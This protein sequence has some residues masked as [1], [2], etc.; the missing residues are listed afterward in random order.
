[1]ARLN[2]P[3][4]ARVTQQARATIPG[5]AG[6]EHASSIAVKSTTASDTPPQSRD[7]ADA[8]GKVNGVH[9][10]MCPH[11]GYDF[12]ASKPIQRGDWLLFPDRTMLEGKPLRLTFQQSVAL[13]TVA[14]AGDEIVT[15]GALLN[16]ISDT[17]NMN[18]V[19]VL[20]SRLKD[21]LGWRYPLETVH[22]RGLR[23]VG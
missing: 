10:P 6:A 11:C 17:G 21:R 23:W 22:G 4:P 2:P 8:A 20:V 7:G 5:E 3:C 1:M 16:C 12:E 13:Y 18:L 15:R 9:I 19:S 14:N